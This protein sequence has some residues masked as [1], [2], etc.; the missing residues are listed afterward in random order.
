MI[1]PSIFKAYDIRGIFPDEINEKSVERIAR[2]YVKFT[3]AKIVAVGCDVRTSSPALKNA[4]ITGLTAM[5]AQVIDIGKVPTE[6]LY[7]AVGFYHYDGGIQVSA[8]HNPAEYNGLKMIRAGVEAISGDSGLEE[9]KLIAQGSDELSS[10]NVGEVHNKDVQED[11]LDFIS[12][13]SSFDNIKPVKIVVNAN[14]GLNGQVFE[15]LLNRLSSTNIE[16]IKL[17]F[18]PDGSFPKG[19]PDPLVAENRAEVSAIVKKENADFA[20]CW[21]ADGDRFFVADEFGE[22][23]ESSITSALLIAQLLSN[24]EGEEAVICDTRNIYAPS[25][26]AENSGAKLLINKAGHTFIKNRMRSE[27]A[28][29]A[30]ETSGHF[31]FRDFYYADSGIFAAVVFLNIIALTNKTVSQL[32]EPLRT[33]F[34]TSG[35]INFKVKDVNETLKDVEQRFEQGQIDRTDGLSVSFDNWRF[36][37]RASNTEEL[38]RL[39]LEAKDADLCQQKTTELVEVLRYHTA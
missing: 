12:A 2:A 11:F 6:L 36:N 39:N 21:D 28:I 24:V 29:F 23:V 30:G 37:V 18:E 20:I 3:G 4:L 35:E 5:G 27:N 1:N 34:F 26:A 32:T 38:V 31:Y 7:F 10:D 19:R 22:F 8:S 25:F 13:H 16:L 15:A 17:N 9:I 14:F 33:K